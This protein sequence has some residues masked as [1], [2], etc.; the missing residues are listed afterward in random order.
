[1]PPWKTSAF[2]VSVRIDKNKNHIF[3]EIQAG[4]ETILKWYLTSTKAEQ[5]IA[6]ALE[7]SL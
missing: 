7:I 6:Y 2:Q 5:S 4:E 3:I 1:M